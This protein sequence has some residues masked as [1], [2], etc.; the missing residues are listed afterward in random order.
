M[1]FPTAG[2]PLLDRSYRFSSRQARAAPGA[3]TNGDMRHPQG[4]TMQPP[5]VLPRRL[6]NIALSSPVWECAM[7]NNAPYPILV[8][9]VLLYPCYKRLKAGRSKDPGSPVKW[10]EGTVCEQGPVR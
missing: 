4:M 8:R 2:L 10:N 6:Q 3:K 9:V 7:Q 5:R 1:T